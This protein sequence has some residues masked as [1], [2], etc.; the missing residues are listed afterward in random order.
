MS[1]NDSHLIENVKQSD[2]DA[3]KTLF[4]QYQPMLFR[5]VVSKVM[6]KDIAED[7]VQETFV[8]VWKIRETLE[9]SKSFFSLIARIGN[10]LSIDHFKHLSVRARHKDQIIQYESRRDNNPYSKVHSSHMQGEILQ[11]VH[12]NLPSKCRNIFLL[13]R[14]EGLANNEI[15]EILDISQRTVENQLYRALKILRK[16]LKDYL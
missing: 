11:A 1:E 2:E 7:I 6:D 15:A 10:N 4:F 16:K 9:P 12:D 8:R 3:F 14:I 5:F 13:S